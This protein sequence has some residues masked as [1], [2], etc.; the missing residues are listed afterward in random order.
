VP[1]LMPPVDSGVAR[2]RDAPQCTIITLTPRPARMTFLQP[3]P[4]AARART[5]A[6]A[7]TLHSERCLIWRR[8]PP[9]H[10]HNRTA[11]V[12]PPHFDVLDTASW[13]ALTH[14]T[15]ARAPRTLG[16]RPLAQRRGVRVCAP[17]ATGLRRHRRRARPP[18]SRRPAV[19]S[20]NKR[21]CVPPPTNTRRMCGAVH[22]PAHTCISSTV[23]LSL[24]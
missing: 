24:P 21:C 6:G 17:A 13:N 14:H 8:P 7:R 1:V 19:A 16:T 5:L 9:R 12:S 23:R 15:R 4:R 10:T 22:R 20:R 2:S 18:A 11:S 3:Q